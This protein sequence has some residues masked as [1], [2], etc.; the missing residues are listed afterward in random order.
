MSQSAR[1]LTHDG[2]S[3][4]GPSSSQRQDQNQ[5]VLD[6]LNQQECSSSAQACGTS[7]RAL[8]SYPRLHP[9]AQVTSARSLPDLMSADAD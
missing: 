7:H 4:P 8:R 6:V 3:V 9:L 2:A 1:P 5:T